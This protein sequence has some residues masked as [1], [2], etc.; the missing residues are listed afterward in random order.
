MLKKRIEFII[1][2]LQDKE[3]EITKGTKGSKILYMTVNPNG[4]A[5]V[6]KVYLRPRPRL[7]K[8]VL[9]SVSRTENSF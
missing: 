1:K 8:F 3:Y 4:E 5:E 7:K 2:A 6:V 9:R